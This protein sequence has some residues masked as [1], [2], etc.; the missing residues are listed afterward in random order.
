[1]S[2]EKKSENDDSNRESIIKALIIIV[3]TVL[4]FVYWI[5]RID[6]IK[7][8]KLKNIKLYRKKLENYIV[9]L[10][11]KREKRDEFYIKAALILR[12]FLYIIWCLLNFIYIKYQIE[13]D[14]EV[15]LES[16]ADS[17]SAFILIFVSTVY[18]FSGKFISP[19]TAIR[20]IKKEIETI[21]DNYLKVDK[22]NQNIKETEIRLKSTEKSE[23]EID[24][25]LTR[26]GFTE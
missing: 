10:Y 12:C 22:L 21:I 1:M 11:R 8:Q 6:L 23:K 24:A 14:K 5:S 13:H 17:N 7:I 25:E 2:S 19:E 15:S 4:A 3:I 18:L 20:F 9:E 16:F 26:L